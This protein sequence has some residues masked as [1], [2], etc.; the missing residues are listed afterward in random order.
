MNNNTKKI[1]GIILFVFVFPAILIAMGIFMYGLDVK[2]AAGAMI[3]GTI[4][5]FFAIG[6]NLIASLK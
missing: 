6:I 4:G 2:A 3:G 1:I 5:A